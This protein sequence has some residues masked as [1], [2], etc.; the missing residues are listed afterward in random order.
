MKLQKVQSSNL[1]AIGYDEENETLIAEFVKGGRY[2]Y[3]NFPKE[4][5]KILLNAPSKGQAFHRY[6]KSKGYAYKKVG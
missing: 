6:V 4:M 1:S 3:Y 5:Y 2:E